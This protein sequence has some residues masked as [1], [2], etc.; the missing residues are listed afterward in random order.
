M[1]WVTKLGLL[2]KRATLHREM[3]EEMA[4]HLEVERRFVLAN[5]VNAIA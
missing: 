5:V 3:E 1:G 4:F 2:F